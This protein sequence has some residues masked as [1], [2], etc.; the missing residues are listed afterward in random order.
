MFISSGNSHDVE[1]DK[2]QLV[3]IIQGIVKGTKVIRLID[4]DEHDPDSIAKKKQKAYEYC[5]KG[6]W[7]V[8]YLMM[9][10]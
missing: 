3:S 7:N 5:Q 2:F 8:I 10:S 6:I 1:N 4:G 9:K